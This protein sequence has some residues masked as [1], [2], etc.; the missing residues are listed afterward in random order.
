[1]DES[2]SISV[3]KKLGIVIRYFSHSQKK[4]VSTFF[5][6]ITLKSSSAKD[7]VAAMTQAIFSAGLDLQ[8]LIGI[9]TDNASVMTGVNEGVFTILKTQ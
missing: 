6:L 8:N 4:V 5:D 9:G 7:I 3:E 1:M 2:T